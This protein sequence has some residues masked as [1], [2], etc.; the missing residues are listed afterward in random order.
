M[1]TKDEIVERVRVIAEEMNAKTKSAEE[2]KA[3]VL[4]DRGRLE[5]LKNLHNM[6]VEAEKA[7]EE[8]KTKAVKK[9]EVKKGSK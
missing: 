2:L 4:V 3:S 9:A 7:V 1:Y 6:I 8:K 5:E